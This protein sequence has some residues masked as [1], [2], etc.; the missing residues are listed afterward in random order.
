MSKSLVTPRDV[1]FIE[2]TNHY[3]E[4]ISMKIFK[5]ALTGGLAIVCILC[6]ISPVMA[7]S[8][9]AV[10]GSAQAR[11]DFRVN[12]QPILSLRLGSPGATIDRIDFNVNQLPPTA[13]PGVSSG[14]NP[15]PV[16]A[17]G[18]VPAGNTITLTA[19]SSTPLTDGTDTIPFTEISWS[20]SGAFSSGTFTGAAAQQIDQFTG[21]GAYTGTYTFSYANS[22]PR[23]SATYDGQVI[24]TLSSP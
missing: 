1:N 7:D 2:G 14:T 22:V 6:F 11:L 13:I 9:V 23:P 3:E 16:A 15:V 18:L 20:A 12:I 5:R 4:D 17:T 19:D 24:Y 21:S 10:G 8:D